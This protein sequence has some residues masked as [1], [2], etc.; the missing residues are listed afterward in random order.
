MQ[1]GKALGFYG[2]KGVKHYALKAGKFGGY[3]VQS[4]QHR[5]ENG[6]TPI[7]V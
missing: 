1:Y 5:T 2:Q 4:S 7:E 3:C 6:F